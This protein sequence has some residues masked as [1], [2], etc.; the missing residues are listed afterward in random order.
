MSPEDVE[1]ITNTY[2]PTGISS[3]WVM[4]DDPTFKDGTPNPCACNEDKT[5]RH[6]LLSC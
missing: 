6:F 4:S 2:H 1:R 5:R 3:Q